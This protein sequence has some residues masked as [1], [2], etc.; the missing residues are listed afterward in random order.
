MHQAEA[1]N[2]GMT[3]LPREITEMELPVVQHFPQW[4]QSELSKGLPDLDVEE[5][6]ERIT[7]GKFL[8]N[9]MWLLIY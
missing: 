2:A 1:L 6:E 7:A 3:E 4:K 8:L 9:K 5:M